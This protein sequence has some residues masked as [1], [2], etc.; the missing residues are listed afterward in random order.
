M[1]DNALNPDDPLTDTSV[2][3]DEGG[4][5]EEA[6]AA[7]AAQEQDDAAKLLAAGTDTPMPRWLS[8]G[9]SIAII[10]MLFQKQIR[11]YW[12]QRGGSRGGASAL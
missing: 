6:G 3:G 2:W 7:A 5:G 12:L 10:L 8:L 4:G 1:G 9:I 11:Q